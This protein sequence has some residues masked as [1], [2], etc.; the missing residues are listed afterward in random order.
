[1]EGFDNNSRWYVMQVM[2]GQENKVFANIRFVCSTEDP[3]N[4]VPPGE[5]VA[6]N[7]KYHVVFKGLVKGI[8]EISIPYKLEEE[9]SKKDNKKIIRE[10]K[11]YPGY[12]LLRTRIYDDNG[13]L[14][15]EN[16][17]FIKDMKGVIGFIGGVTPVP[18]SEQEVAEM[19]RI[20]KDNEEEKVVPRITYNI[21]ESVLIKT[22]S[23][24]NT[25]GV[26]ESIDEKNNTLKLSVSI[27]GRSTTVVTSV[28]Q[29]ER[30]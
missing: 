4:V 5:G 26:I 14:I 3:D 2:S 24:E 13:T 10:R 29:V 20:E 11:L 15:P 17:S 22:G 23:F 1:M 21:G 16:W 7:E 19:M 8:Y 18:L 27:F 30:P 9:R 6:R 25:E 12:V 28:E